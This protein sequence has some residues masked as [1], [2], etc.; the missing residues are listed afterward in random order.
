[1]LKLAKAHFDSGAYEPAMGKYVE[2]GTKFPKHPW[3]AVAELGK[4]HCQEAIG[5]TEQALAGF[6]AFVEQ[7][8]GHFLKSEAVFGR[9]RCLETLGRLSEAKAVYEDFIAAN[10]DSGWV[11]RAEELLEQVKRKLGESAGSVALQ[12]ATTNAVAAPV[13]QK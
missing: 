2:F 5:Q 6:S 1:M 3:A 8:P 10:P 7:H 9:G 13:E 11:S 12:A 4:I